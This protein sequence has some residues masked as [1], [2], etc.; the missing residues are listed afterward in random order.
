MVAVEHGQFQIP[1]R[2]NKCW[3]SVLPT[4]LDSLLSSDASIP[5]VRSVFSLRLIKV[6]PLLLGTRMQNSSRA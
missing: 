4:C 1:K 3:D 2:A 5:L 6:D